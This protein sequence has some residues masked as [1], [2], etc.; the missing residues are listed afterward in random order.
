MFENHLL[1]MLIYL[2]V[3][4]VFLALGLLSEDV[5]RQVLFFILTAFFIFAIFRP[6]RLS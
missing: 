2:V 5:N 1:E 6:T 4:L 3:G